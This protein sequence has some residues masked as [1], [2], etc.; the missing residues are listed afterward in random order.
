MPKA[1]VTSDEEKLDHNHKIYLCFSVEKICC[2]LPVLDKV[3][4]SQGEKDD[5]G[6]LEDDEAAVEVDKLRAVQESIPL[7]LIGSID[8]SGA[9]RRT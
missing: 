9:P 4:D 3:V 5:I 7:A 2:D 1:L 8:I 6:C